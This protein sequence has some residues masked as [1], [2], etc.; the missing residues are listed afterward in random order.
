MR[1]CRHLVLAEVAALDVV[2]G[3]ARAVEAAAVVVEVPVL[4]SGS[5]TDRNLLE[6]LPV[7][8]SRRPF[9]GGDQPPRAQRTVV[10]VSWLRAWHSS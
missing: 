3:V 5:G 9:A 10:S 4:C 7:L 2:V 6:K 1:R 8:P